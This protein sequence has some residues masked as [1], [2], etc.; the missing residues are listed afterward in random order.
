MAEIV[1]H[2]DDTVKES[3]D[4]QVVVDPLPADHEM[5]DL[6]GLLLPKGNASP[7]LSDPGL[8]EVTA[9]ADDGA[10]AVDKVSHNPR[11]YLSW[12]GQATL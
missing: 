2:D 9:E 7:A 12:V 6:M 8:S 4:D 1:N 3:P 11:R 5:D 10:A